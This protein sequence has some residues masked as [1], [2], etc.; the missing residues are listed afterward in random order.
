M[1]AF[2]LAAEMKADGIE[3]DVQL[4]KDGEVVVV[5]DETV[6]RVFMGSGAVKDFTYTQLRAMKS[7]NAPSDDN[8]YMPTLFEVMEF[9]APLKL[10]LNIE[11]KTSIELYPGIEQQVVDLVM[12]SGMKEKVLYSSFNHL[13]LRKIKELSPDARIGLLYSGILADPWAYAMCIDADAIHPAKNSL[14]VPDL[15]QNCHQHGI[16]VNVWTIDEPT[17]MR[18]CIANGADGIITNRPDIAL[19]QI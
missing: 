15:I 17:L 6:D 18:F 16:A 14:Q 2:E 5:H 3:L 4:T 19:S 9:C 10:H 7:K 12:R 8:A 1:S 13:S 11:L